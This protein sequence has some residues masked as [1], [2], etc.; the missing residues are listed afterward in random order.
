MDDVIL[1]KT[2]LI[3]RCLRR[4]REDYTGHEIEFET[5]CMRQ[6]AIL[7]NLQRACESSIDLAAHVIRLKK[8]GLPQKSRDLFVLLQEASLIDSGLSQ[9]LQGMVGFRNI[10]VHNYQQLNLEIVRNLLE[11]RLVDFECF[12]KA[13]L[14]LVKP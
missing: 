14:S 8:L 3:E 4:I 12:T 7:L 2:A 10:A 5:S 6:D 11:H 13:M 9:R 1:N